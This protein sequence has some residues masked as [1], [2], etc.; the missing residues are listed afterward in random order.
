VSLCIKNLYYLVS[1]RVNSHSVG[2][3]AKRF[4]RIINKFLFLLKTTFSLIQDHIFAET[5]TRFCVLI[6]LNIH[7]E[8]TIE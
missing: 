6:V 8:L 5:I 4:I 3:N 1:V 2:N 7:G